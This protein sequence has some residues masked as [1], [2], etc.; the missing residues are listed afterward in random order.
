MSLSYK[1]CIGLFVVIITAC[2]PTPLAKIKAM[3]NEKQTEVEV[4]DSVEFVYKE[5][6]YTR[7]IVTAD[8]VYHYNK[9]NNKM[10]FRN[11][12]VRFYDKQKLVSVL[13]AKYGENNDN[14]KWIKVSGNVHM[15][16]YKWEIMETDE[17]IWNMQARK[18]WTERPVIIKT[19]DNFIR[20]A[21]F[22]S[23]EDF[24]N[25]TI[26]KISGIVHVDD[27]KGF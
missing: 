26:R 10:E 27:T 14:E 20:G 22:I 25:Y 5:N 12:V 2:E 7:A 18:V 9:N 13:E 16:N 1:F 8:T 17:L 23:D 19:P 24:S 15:E 4:A 6:E 21:S 11:M 3:F